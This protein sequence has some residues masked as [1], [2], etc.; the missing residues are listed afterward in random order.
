MR[1]SIVVLALLLAISG[2]EEVEKG[3]SEGVI[4]AKSTLSEQ[5]ETPVVVEEAVETEPV[6][7]G[8]RIEVAEEPVDVEPVEEATAVEVA[9]KTVEI[10]TAVEAAKESVEIPIKIEP[11]KKP[12]ADKVM[13][14]VNGIKIMQSVVD[15][16]VDRLLKSRLEA[17]KARGQQVLPGMLEKMKEQSKQARPRIANMLIEKKLWENTF[18]ANNVEV[19]E[20]E[21]MAK[22][23]EITK[24]RGIT[25]DGLTKELSRFGLSMAEFKEQIRMP[26]S[27]EKVVKQEMAEEIKLIT[28]EEAKK[29]YDNNSRRYNIPEQVKVSH[30]LAGGRGIKDEN[31]PK[32]EEKIEEV[33]KKLDSGGNF[34]EL[35]REYSDCP[36]SSD[37]GDLKVFFD[38][39]GLITGGRR[40]GMDAKFTEAAFALEVGQISDIVETPFGYHIIKLADRRQ[41][42]TTSF[43]EAK[44]DIISELESGKYRELMRKYIEKMKS[45]AEIVWVEEKKEADTERK[46][47]KPETAVKSK[48]ADKPA[49][50]AVEAEK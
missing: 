25:L 21:I 29:Y 50:E 36:S 48:D 19:G 13:V 27:A 31:R 12:V 33:K 20:E 6:E 24:M 3:K 5:S 1:V 11:V 22:I 49:G 26:L 43:E 46:T 17:M 34:E 16:E 47:E 32:L 2:C 8:V 45:E 38:K 9:E 41:A 35:A 42:K 37:G 30:I 18:A 28:E 23:E 44:A 15:K 14:T 7:A 10:E 39:T 40:G 4:E